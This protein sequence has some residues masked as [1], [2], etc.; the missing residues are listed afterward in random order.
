MIPGPE[1]RPTA[2]GPK[3]RITVYKD[4]D[5][6]H[7]VLTRRSVTGVLLF[8]NN[9]PV[10]WISK[11]QK[12]VETST[13]GAELVA[14]R[15]TTDLI[16]EYWYSL[17]MMGCEPDGPALLLHDNNSVVLNYTMPN[18]VLKKKCSVCAYHRVREAVA[19]GMMKFTHIPSTMNYADILTNPMSGTQLQDLVSPLLLRVPMDLS[20]IHI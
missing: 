10:R 4:S 9:T 8:L 3:I 18:S 7:D 16:L 15:I 5:H 17:R 13:Y 19:G 11:R 14:V 1:E 6:A 12:T 20:L 2:T